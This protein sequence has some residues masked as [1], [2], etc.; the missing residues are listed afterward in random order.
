[1]ARTSL[2]LPFSPARLRELRE[3]A[4]LLQQAL[5]DRTAEAGYP[6][7]R[8]AISHFEIGT[9]PPSAPALKA[10]AEALGA[11]VDDLLDPAS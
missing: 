5:A 8:G 1:M 10:L 6:V 11:S 3:R 2:A 9:R 4:G 7:S